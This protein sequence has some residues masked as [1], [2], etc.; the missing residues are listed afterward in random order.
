MTQATYIDWERIAHL[1]TRTGVT[2]ERAITQLLTMTSC[3]LLYV[4]G[5]SGSWIAVVAGSIFLAIPH[6]VRR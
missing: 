4:G 1:P 3:A 6:F 5:A 2:I